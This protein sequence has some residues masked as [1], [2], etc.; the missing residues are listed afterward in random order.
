MLFGVGT[1][2]ITA[3]TYF[4]SKSISACKNRDFYLRNMHFLYHAIAK[5]K[6]PLSKYSPNTQKFSALKCFKYFQERS[7]SKS[8]A[9]AQQTVWMMS[10]PRCWRSLTP[11]DRP[12]IAAYYWSVVTMHGSWR[13]SE[14]YYFYFYSVRDSL[15]VTLRSLSASTLKN[16]RRHG[17]RTYN[18]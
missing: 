8:W 14:I 18:W 15:T 4:H 16:V 13:I 11:F 5:W 17:G 9:T 3:S 1:R 7:S 12:Y 6:F 2:M 10:H